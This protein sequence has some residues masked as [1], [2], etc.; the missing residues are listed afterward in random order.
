MSSSVAT[1]PTMWDGYLHANVLGTFMNRPRVAPVADALRAAGANAA[2][3]GFPW[4]GTCI[5]RTGTNQGPKGLRE[6]SEQFLTYNANTGVDLT[7]TLNIVD[8]GDVA[9]VPGNSIATQQRA[10]ALVAT[11]LEAD[12]IPVIGGGDHSITIGPA[13]AFAKKYANCGKHYWT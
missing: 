6:A 1:D 11:L 12:V 9:V 8:C 10:E 7:D 13:R 5:S 2:F 3:L 4:D